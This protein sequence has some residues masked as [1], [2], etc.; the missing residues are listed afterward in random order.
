MEYKFN[1]TYWFKNELA[2][3]NMQSSGKLVEIDKYGNYLM[4]NSRYGYITV[5]KE[6]LDA[7][8]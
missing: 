7:H 5:T 4:F 3:R 2:G 8:N 6:N 1:E